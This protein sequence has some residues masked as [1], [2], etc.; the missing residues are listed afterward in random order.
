MNNTAYIITK[1]QST[2]DPP[3]ELLLL[4][5]ETREAI[6]KYLYDSDVYLVKENLKPVAVFAL[7]AVNDTELEIKNIAVSEKLQGKGIGS[8]L[9]NEI[10]RIAR[11]GNYQSLIV[12]TPDV[13][14]KQIHFYEKNGF[15]KYD[16]KKNYYI[17][18]YTQPIIE[19]GVMLLD[20]M[21]LK[22]KLN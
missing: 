13:S 6:E 14:F 4:A 9:I 18:H 1:T 12:G 22:M 10:A 20:M 15:K 2:D 16:V 7:C 19:D 11:Q 5:D 3:F 8:Y 21:M 17:D